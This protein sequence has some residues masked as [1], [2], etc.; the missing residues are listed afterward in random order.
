M[1]AVIE[2]IKDPANILNEIKRVLTHDGILIIITPNL[3]KVK[4]NFFDDPTHVK[5]YNPRNITWLMSLFGFK[6]AFVGL[7]TVNKSPFI[8]KLPE[9]IQFFYGNILPFSGFKKMAPSFLKG[10]SKSILCAFS[11]QKEE[12]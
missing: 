4:F 11:L 2:H 8:W 5:P 7:W 9:H 6:K 10:K 1:Y 3:D 12:R